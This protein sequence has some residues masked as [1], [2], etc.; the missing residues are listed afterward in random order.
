VVHFRVGGALVAIVVALGT[1]ACGSSDD[2]GSK[3]GNEPV[4]VALIPPL[5]GALGE[6]GKDTVKAWQY[7]A[8]EAN[9]HGGVDGHQV[10]IVTTATDGSPATTVRLA[11]QALSKDGAHFL[12]A[13][14]TGPENS[15]LQKQLPSM[16]AL[17][18][19]ATANDDV[20]GEQECSAYAFRAVQS[21]QM[22][23]NGIV[24]TLKSLP[25][26]RWAIQAVDYSIGHSAADAFKAAAA[27]AGKQV[28]LTQFSP[29]GTTDFGS[30]ITKLKNSGAD[31]L[32]SVTFGADAVALINQGAQFKL[33]DTLKTVL[34]FNQV[35]EPLFPALGQKIL[36]FYNQVNY[37]V[38]AANPANKAFVAGWTKKYGSAPYYVPADTYLAA[39][40]L[41]EGIER[42][43]STD[44]QKVRAALPGARY[45][46]VTGPVTVRPQDNQLLRSSYVGQVV[47]KAGGPG[48]LGFK[49]V[50]E[51]PAKVTTPSASPACQK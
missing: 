38:D 29:L 17:L 1:V 12:A 30:Q 27:K 40:M 6:F 41:F 18:F 26:R 22:D 44:P 19:N 7:A 36:G 47:K 23:M 3:G 51:T 9:A 46:S 45:D 31:A 39:Q 13:V 50:A 5:S 25:G 48:G 32:F 35:S 37:D 14:M 15:A 43:H 11:R 20:L 4:T 2:E 34:G 10:K 33:F 42:A 16:D 21:A 24:N 28:V 49:I 8:D